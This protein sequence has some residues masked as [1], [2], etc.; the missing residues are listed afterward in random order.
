MV[1]ALVATAAHAA[2]TVGDWENTNDGWFDW[3]ASNGGSDNAGNPGATPAVDFPSSVYTYSTEGAT[4]GTYALAMSP[5]SGYNQNMSWKSEWQTDSQGNSEMAD[6]VNNTMLAITVTFNS[7]EWTGD[8]YDA[9]GLTFNFASAGGTNS[10]FLNLVPNNAPSFMPQPTYDTGNPSYPGGWDPTNYPGVTTRTMI[11]DYGDYVPA[12]ING[13]ANTMTLSQLMGANPEYAEFIFATLSDGSGTY[14]I[15]NASLTRPQVNATWSNLAGPNADT[16]YHWGTI[17]NWGAGQGMPSNAGDIVTFGN[18]IGAPEVVTLN[19]TEQFQISVGTMNFNSGESYTIAQG[20]GGTLTLNG[21]V[22][23]YNYNQNFGASTMSVT[24]AGAQINDEFGNHTISAPVSLATGVTIAVGQS[25][26]TFTISGNISGA[27][28]ITLNGTTSALSAGTT[29]LSGINT[30]LGATTVDSGTL[31]IGGAAS[32]PTGNALAIGTAT[33]TGAVQ[34]ASNT[35]SKTLSSLTINAGSTLD[36]TNNHLFLNYAAGTQATAD[37]TI[38]GYLV[39]GY[40]GG[41]WNGAGIDSS[42]AAVTSGYAVGYADG[43]DGVVTG[44]PSGQ[45]ELKYTLAGDA[46]LDGVVSGVDFTIL[47]GNLGKSVNAWDK[48]DFNYDG[49][50]SGTDFTALVGNLGKSA[51]GADVT[52]P[53]ADL[54]AIDAFAAAN[55]LM[56]SVPEPTSAGLLIAAGVGMLARR[57]RSS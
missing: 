40:A 55:G 22:T 24:N 49:V 13:N 44:L 25:N 39:S 28:G 30:Y 1:S 12:T 5:A 57:R 37:S 6:V 38:R 31:V 51:N 3:G 42:T 16:T 41:T 46:N 34:L 56:T 52:L 20:T 47:V 18:A 10:G 9:I 2:T 11:W 19:G 7:A 53:A 23:N 50:V 45:I 35:G 48:G 26:N 17:A 43:A 4:L 14:H 15:D 8:T 27:G 21:N 54:A 29:V 33:T 32:L 36:I